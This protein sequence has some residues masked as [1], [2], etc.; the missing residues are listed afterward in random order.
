MCSQYVLTLQQQ[1]CT[2]ARARTHTHTHSLK[3]V[4]R[5]AK[6]AISIGNATVQN[7]NVTVL[8]H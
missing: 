1:N 4:Q 2:R 8:E 3:R 6:V 7:R 5:F